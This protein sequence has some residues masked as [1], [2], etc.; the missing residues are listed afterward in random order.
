M[1]R[2]RQRKWREMDTWQ[3]YA[4][5]GLGMVCM[6]LGRPVRREGFMTKVCTDHGW[7]SCPHL[8]SKCSNPRAYVFDTVTAVGLHLVTGT[9][10]RPQTRW[11]PNPST[12]QRRTNILKLTSP[13]G[14]PRYKHRQDTEA[15]TLVKLL[16]Q[17][18]RIP[19]FRRVYNQE[20]GR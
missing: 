4:D 12:F 8:E 7:R 9:H 6:V 3:W 14:G 15:Q 13:G 1:I 10:G 11:W 5:M 20:S 19:V 17:P 2:L 18:V 16:E